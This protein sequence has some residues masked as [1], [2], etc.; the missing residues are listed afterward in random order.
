[1]SQSGWNNA[2]LQET[3]L[4]QEPCRDPGRMFYAG[5]VQSCEVRC[6]SSCSFDVTQNCPPHSYL[7]LAS[8]GN[9]RRHDYNQ[10]ERKARGREGLPGEK[11]IRRCWEMG[12]V[13]A[14]AGRGRGPAPVFSGLCPQQTWEDAPH[15]GR[16]AG[17]QATRLQLVWRNPRVDGCTSSDLSVTLPTSSTN[18]CTA[19]PKQ[20]FVFSC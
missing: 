2:R 3:A 12:R 16:L 20:M 14:Q 1:M 9:L 10:R 8:V 15:T 6:R 7:P 11:R 18:I 17:T 19:S 13:G 5:I 4:G